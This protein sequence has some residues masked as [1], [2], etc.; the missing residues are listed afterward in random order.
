MS[1]S[2]TAVVIDDHP[3]VARGIADFLKSHC[4][5]NYVH[6]IS[7]I[8]DFWVLMDGIPQ[9]ALVVLD[10]WLPDGASLPLLDQIMM[11]YPS[12]PVLVMSADDDIAVQK[13][14]QTAGAQGFINKQEPPEV[15]VRAV[16]SLLCHQFWFKSPTHLHSVKELPISATELGLTERQGEIL[17]LILQGLPNK[18]IAKLLTLSEQTVKEHVSGI[19][20][21]LGVRNRIEVI[22]KLRGKRLE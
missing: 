17:S 6:A 20:E 18:Q 12:L 16:T 4:G 1:T 8:A 3:L 7:S 13:K 10:F 21:R 5:F 19:L 15:F 9:T 2:K 22:T 11:R 14:V